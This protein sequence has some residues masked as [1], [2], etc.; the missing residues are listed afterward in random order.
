MLSVLL[1]VSWIF[2]VWGEHSVNHGRLCSG[3]DVCEECGHRPLLHQ[4][5]MGFSA[6]VDSTEIARAGAFNCNKATKWIPGNNYTLL[7]H[8]ASYNYVHFIHYNIQ[9][10]LYNSFS[11]LLC[12]LPHLHHL[13]FALFLHT[14]SSCNIYTNSNLYIIFLS[15]YVQTVYIIYNFEYIFTFLSYNTST[16]CNLSCVHMLLDK[17]VTVCII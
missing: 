9:C 8:T 6:R 2:P 17:S 15:I 13:V 1:W 16:Y 12:T 4:S 5:T 7:I 10:I 11:L 14:S 3:E